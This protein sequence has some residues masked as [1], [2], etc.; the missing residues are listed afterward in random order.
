MDKGY[1]YTTMKDATVARV[2]MPGI[3]SSSNASSGAEA[4]W[5]SAWSRHLSRYPG[6]GESCAAHA[7]ARAAANLLL[8]VF[9]LASLKRAWE[10]LH[11]QQSQL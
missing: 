2:D 10:C 7:E 6:P 9:A 8:Q 11:A 5:T 4:M 1:I 3:A